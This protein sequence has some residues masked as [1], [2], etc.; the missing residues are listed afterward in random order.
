M[1]AHEIRSRLVG[2]EED[3]GLVRLGDFIAHCRNLSA[4]LRTSEAVVAGAQPVIGY[5]ITSL[6]A[7]SAELVLEPVA[8]KKGKDRRAEV[9]DFFHS[10]VEAIQ[11]GATP[12]SRLHLADFEVFQKLVEPLKHRVREVLL[13]GMALTQQ[14]AANIE[15]IL[16]TTIPAHGS[17]SGVLERVNVHGG[18]EFAIYPP[19][20]DRAIRCSFPEAMLP[21]VCRAIKRNVTVAGKL[22]YQPGKPLPARIAVEKMDIH[23]PDDELPTLSSL[24][25]VLAGCL[26]AMD[27]VAFV[28]SLRDEQQA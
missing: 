9:I 28:R 13:D 8:P 12:D 6:S 5:R 1:T 11:T 19:I 16:G 2:A 17:A 3:G 26:G 27:S 10:T 25:G 18:F 14:Y 23:P 21:D 20:G 15:K 24:K 7:H 4:C 22:T